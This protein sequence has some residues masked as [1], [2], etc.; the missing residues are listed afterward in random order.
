[1]L[2]EFCDACPRFTSD[3]DFTPL[4]HISNVGQRACTL[5][6]GLFIYFLFVTS[7]VLRDWFIT[8]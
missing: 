2:L 1:M 4:P 7:T 5:S 3:K 8:T 6:S